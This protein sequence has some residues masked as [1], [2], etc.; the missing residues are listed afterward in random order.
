MS[1]PAIPDDLRA[2]LEPFLFAAAVGCLIEQ[3]CRAA[4][5]DQRTAR[6]LIGFPGYVGHYAAQ[7]RVSWSDWKRLLDAAEDAGLLKPDDDKPQ[8]D[9]AGRFPEAPLPDAQLANGGACS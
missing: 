2:A 5:P 7:S 3:D 8:P 9:E 6:P 1:D 4:R